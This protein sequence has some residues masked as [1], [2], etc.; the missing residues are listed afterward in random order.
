MKITTTEMNRLDHWN[1][2]QDNLPYIRIES[3]SDKVEV[4]FEQESLSC[5]IAKGIG[6]FVLVSG[7][8]AGSYLILDQNL[9][10]HLIIPLAS[11]LELS[12]M[13]VALTPTPVSKAKK[14]FI[15]TV[16]TV[17]TATSLLGTYLHDPEDAPNTVLFA[18]WF[19]QLI[20][21]GLMIVKDV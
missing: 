15:L 20:G 6:R 11:A 13:A 16:I 9:S 17:C 10:N 19:M 3:T 12:A 1:Y 7:L 2:T 5:T 18:F 4:V 14:A 8:F 21:N